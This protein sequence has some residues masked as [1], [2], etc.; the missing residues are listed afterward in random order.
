MR[1][2]NS[3]ITEEDFRK[4]RARRDRE[5]LDRISQSKS[6]N[7]QWIAYING[8]DSDYDSVPALNQDE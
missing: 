3:F 1:W 8:F 4:E 5:L 7:K 6:L 2:D